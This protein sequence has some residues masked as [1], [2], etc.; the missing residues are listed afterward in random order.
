VTLASSRVQ[1]H[2]NLPIPVTNPGL[3]DLPNPQPKCAPRLLGA[4]VPKSGNRNPCHLAGTPMAHLVHAAQIVHQWAAARGLYNFFASTSCNI[5]LSKLSSVSGAARTAN[6]PPSQQH[7]HEGHHCLSFCQVH[8]AF[9]AESGTWYSS[10]YLRMLRAW[11][12]FTLASRKSSFM[13]TAIAAVPGIF[14]E[15]MPFCVLFNALSV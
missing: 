2:P 15:S 13:R 7:R 10:F 12:S 6:S 14:V 11:S 9:G 4:L 5:V 1:Q 3:S 8:P